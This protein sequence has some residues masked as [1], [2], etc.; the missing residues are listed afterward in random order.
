MKNMFKLSAVE[1]FAQKKK[2]MFE[3]YIRLKHKDAFP[4]TQFYGVKPIV[5]L[6]KYF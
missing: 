3:C 2:Y 5:Y 6:K 1:S 4:Q